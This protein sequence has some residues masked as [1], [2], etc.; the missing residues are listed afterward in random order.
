MLSF[1]KVLTKSN[2]FKVKLSIL[3]I[4]SITGFIVYL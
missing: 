3:I 1:M 4:F 2:F